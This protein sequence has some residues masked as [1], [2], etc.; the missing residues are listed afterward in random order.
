MLCWFLF[1]SLLSIYNKEMFGKK[2][3][4]FPCPLLMT[5]VHFAMQWGVSY[6]LSKIWPDRFGGREVDEMSWSTFLNVSVSCGVVTSLDVA[7]SNL[8]MVF[9]TVTFYTMVKSS[10]PIFTLGFAF[11]LRIEKV[12]LKLLAVVGLIAIGELLAVY[13]ESD[14]N[15]KGFILCLS[16]SGLSGLRWTLVQLKL[17]KLNPPLQSPIAT[18]RVIAPSMYATILLV[19][20][21]YERPWESFSTSI[22]FSDFSHIVRTVLLAM[23]GGGLAVSMMLAEFALILKSSAMILMIGGVIKEL[24]TISLGVQIFDDVLTVTNM[25]GFGIVLAGVL[26]FKL[27]YKKNKGGDR[28]RNGDDISSAEDE[29][30]LEMGA[31]LNESNA[32]PMVIDMKEAVNSQEGR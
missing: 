18:L 28:D 26:L 1:S 2:L 16:A 8:S 29:T 23:L 30:E 31:L 24:F 11:F 17:S 27:S 19:S 25:T 22:Y 13:G 9:I 21:V 32:L 20:L 10:S 6:T 3:G 14:F 12:Q 4:H 15:L 7:L 5:S